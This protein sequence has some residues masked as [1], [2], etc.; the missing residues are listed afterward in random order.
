MGNPRYVVPARVNH[1]ILRFMENHL[2]GVRENHMRSFLVY[3]EEKGG[4]LCSPSLPFPPLPFFS[5]LLLA[6]QT[7]RHIK[8]NN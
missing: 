3:N 8:R 5:S 6:S 1:R 2:D 7:P 4:L